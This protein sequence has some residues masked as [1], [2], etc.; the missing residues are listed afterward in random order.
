M[1]YLSRTYMGVSENLG[2]L[3][4]GLLIIRILLGS[5]FSGNSHIKKSDRGTPR[6][7]ISW[8][9]VG[10]PRRR[11][12]RTI[13]ISVLGFRA[14]FGVPYLLKLAMR[15]T[16]ELSCEA[17]GRAGDILAFSSLVFRM[18]KSLSKPYNPLNQLRR[19][20]VDRSTVFLLLIGL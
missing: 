8:V 7:E 15:K 6:R 16:A 5:P 14:Y 9:Q 20:L 4:L 11:C 17:Y 12:F 10:F 19:C 18:L 2:Y 3:I 1:I 13:R